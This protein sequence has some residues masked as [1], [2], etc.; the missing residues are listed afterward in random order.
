MIVLGVQSG[1]VLPCPGALHHEDG[2]VTGEVLTRRRAP[3]G[4][5][6]T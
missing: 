5:N 2:V 4:G 6:V 3:S 1:Q